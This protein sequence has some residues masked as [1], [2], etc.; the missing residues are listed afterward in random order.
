MKEVGV[1]G[2]HE[3][4]VELHCTVTCA[5]AGDEKPRETP[6]TVEQ[7]RV[8]LPRRREPQM[9]GSGEDGPRYRCKEFV[10]ADHAAATE[11]A[12]KFANRALSGRVSC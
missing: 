7:P 2:E 11:L 1:G 9:G 6:S 10:G 4:Q 8:T 12:L 5:F 3:V